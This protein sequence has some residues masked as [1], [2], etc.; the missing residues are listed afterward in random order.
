MFLLSFFRRRAAESDLDDEMQYHLEQEIANNIRAGM[1]PEEARFAAQRLIGPIPLY[2]E[3]CRDARAASMLEGYTRDLR[4]AARTL[5]RAPLFTSLAIVT[6]ALG[7]GA[8]TTVFT[9]IEN[10]LLCRC[11]FAIP[12]NS[13]C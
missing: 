12:S 5:R 8:N 4:Y 11:R 7:I 10:I 1:T 3:E 6:L 9:F 13:R 2:K